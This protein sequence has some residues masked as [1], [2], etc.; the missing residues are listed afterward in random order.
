[1]RGVKPALIS[2]RTLLWSGGSVATIIT[3]RRS[4][5]N[6]TVV[7]PSYAE[8]VATEGGHMG[9]GMPQDGADLA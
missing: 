1:M 4:G 2:R 9:P 7:V 5:G 6:G 3:P 8:N